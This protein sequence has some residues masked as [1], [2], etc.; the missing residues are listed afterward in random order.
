MNLELCTSTFEGARLAAGM[1]FKRIELCSA[2]ELGGLTPSLGL[3]KA[4]SELQIEVHAM[5]RHR[6]GSF[7]YLDN[8]IEVMRLDIYSLSD[9]GASGVV[10]GLLNENGGVDNRT[11]E[12][13][14]LADALDLEVTFHRAFDEVLDQETAME[15]LID[16]GIT[17]VLTSGGA[18]SAEKGLAKIR[19]LQNSF[20]DRIQIMAGGG[21]TASNA[22]EIAST[23]IDNLH[24]T[25]H[26]STLQERPAMGRNW[27]P[28]RAKMEEIQRLFSG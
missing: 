4:C 15:K 21:I 26:F 27:I 18:S 3:A 20:G 11:H 25:A 7:C 19:R 13:V 23:G 10:F 28:D 22:I 14:K 6:A 24:F 1:G 16:Y 5:V 2:L 17:R 9:A 8:D 12:L